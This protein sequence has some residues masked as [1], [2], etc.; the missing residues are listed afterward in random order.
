MWVFE[1]QVEF[2]GQKL[3]LTQVINEHHENVKY[4][5]GVK[6][7]EN[8][9]AVPD[10]L[11]AVEGA[12]M[13]VFVIPHQFLAGIC[14][15]LSKVVRPEVVRACS[16]IKVLNKIIKNKKFFNRAWMLMKRKGR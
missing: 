13:W 12:D 8:I 5:P 11:A 16:L 15:K 6:L 10:L 9:R 14:D 3:P 2:G 1:E 7:P 4:L